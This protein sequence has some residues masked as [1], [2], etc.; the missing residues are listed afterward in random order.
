MIPIKIGNVSNS[1]RK[2]RLDSTGENENDGGRNRW[3]FETRR[4]GNETR[5]KCAS[6][7]Q[8]ESESCF[9]DSVLVSAR[10]EFLRSSGYLKISP[11]S[12]LEIRFDF[13]SAASITQDR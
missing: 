1:R 12:V 2:R 8:T 6:F 11:R 4:R 3:Q 9:D 13:F 10:E 5:A 7:S